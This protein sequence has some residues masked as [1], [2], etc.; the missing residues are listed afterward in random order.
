MEHISLR[1]LAQSLYIG[2]TASK[3]GPVSAVMGWG[4]II[5]ASLWLI[6]VPEG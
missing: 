4:L 2:Q 3:Y 6:N 5:G 1:K